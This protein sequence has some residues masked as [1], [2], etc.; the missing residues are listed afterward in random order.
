[1]CLTSLE[2]RRG[3]LQILTGCWVLVLDSRRVQ[4]SDLPSPP[5]SPCCVSETHRNMLVLSFK[6]RWCLSI[7]LIA[8]SSENEKETHRSMLHVWNNLSSYTLCFPCRVNI[9]VPTSRWRVL[10]ILVLGLCPSLG[11]F[12]S[13]S[14]FKNVEKI[15]NLSICKPTDLDLL[16]NRPHLH[17]VL[18]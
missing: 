16:T 13:F 1:M 6:C 14:C 5:R 15:Q 9:L 2:T 18:M 11:S 7:S 4:S 10:L 3:F 8:D 17:T 12:L